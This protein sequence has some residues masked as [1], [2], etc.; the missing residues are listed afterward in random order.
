MSTSLTI[1]TIPFGSDSIVSESFKFDR[2]KF[3]RLVTVDDPEQERIS[4]QGFYYNGQEKNSKKGVASLAFPYTRGVAPITVF[5]PFPDTLRQQLRHGLRHIRQKDDVMNSITRKDFVEQDGKTFMSYWV[6]DISE[7]DL[8]S[9]FDADK[10]STSLLNQAGTIYSPA[11]ASQ[12]ETLNRWL[13]DASQLGTQLSVVPQ[14]YVLP[15][16]IPNRYPGFSEPSLVTPVVGNGLSYNEYT[17]IMR[18]MDNW[19]TGKSKSKM[20][21]FCFSIDATGRVQEYRTIG[22]DFFQESAGANLS[23]V[24]YPVHDDKYLYFTGNKSLPDQETK[25][26]LVMPVRD[27]PNLIQQPVP[28][29]KLPFLVGPVQIGKKQYASIAKMSLGNQYSLLV[30]ELP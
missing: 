1:N 20:K 24:R 15:E 26:T 25:F 14:Q 21:L 29:S 30:F 23:L 22:Y 10:E 5:N 3:N 8:P 6:Y 13:N 7:L 9:D 19:K 18:K 12:T 28:Y 4:L 11:G 27:I 17:S 16:N 2:V